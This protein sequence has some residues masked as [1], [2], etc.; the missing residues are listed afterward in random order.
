MVKNSKYQ[1]I[2]DHLLWITNLLLVTESETQTSPWV[3]LIESVL[4]KSHR[5][6][7]INQKMGQLFK[8]KTKV[9][10]PKIIVKT[11]TIQYRTWASANKIANPSKKVQF[12]TIKVLYAIM[13]LM[14]KTFAAVIRNLNWVIIW[15]NKMPNVVHDFYRRLLTTAR[16]K[17]SRV[18]L[19]M[20]PKNQ[21]KARTKNWIIFRIK[22]QQLCLTIEYQFSTMKTHKVHKV[23]LIILA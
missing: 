1:R 6:H 12:E 8:P 23:F 4:T 9:L 14:L 22:M 5:L 21:N 20:P 10:V 16:I 19:L 13:T 3:C 15:K 7:L 11:Q 18:L 17:W 2:R